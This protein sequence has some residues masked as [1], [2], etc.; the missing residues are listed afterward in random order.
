MRYLAGPRGPTDYT[1]LG[2][3]ASELGKVPLNGST[4]AARRRGFGLTPSPFVN[5]G[6][7]MNNKRHFPVHA[8][9]SYAPLGMAGVTSGHSS[10]GSPS[11]RV[12]GAF[13]ILPNSRCG[14]DP[15]A[16]SPAP[17]EPERSQRLSP[18]M[19]QVREQT[20]GRRGQLTTG[21]RLPRAWTSAPSCAGLLTEEREL[22]ALTEIA[23]A[24]PG[25][26]L[27]PFP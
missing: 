8:V 26:P 9:P 18:L 1:R 3:N 15:P 21:D 25:C 16:V 4:P 7:I 12:R 19:Q 22:A 13:A 6:L 5:P 24:P 23:A 17:C 10:S 14:H 2:E 11:P 20:A 27:A